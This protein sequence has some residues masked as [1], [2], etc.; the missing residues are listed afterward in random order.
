MPVHVEETRLPGIGSKFTL[1]L[2][3]GGR[4]AVI[5]HNDGKRELYFYRPPH[6]HH[7][8]RVLHPG[9]AQ[10]DTTAGRLRS[11][12]ATPG[13]GAR[14]AEWASRAKVGITVIAILR[15]PEPITG[16]Q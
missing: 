11:R 7:P 10:A 3:S 4:L 15:E 9:D 14:A 2:D 13:L 16:A 12:A 6:P 5:L 8:A 1:R